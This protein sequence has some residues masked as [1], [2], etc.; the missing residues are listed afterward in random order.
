MSYWLQTRGEV[1]PAPIRGLRNDVLDG[2]AESDDV[3]S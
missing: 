3:V 1:R 2:D